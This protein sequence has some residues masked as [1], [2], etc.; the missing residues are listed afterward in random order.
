MEQIMI[1]IKD[2]ESMIKLGELLVDYAYPN[3]VIAL[4]GDLGAGKTTLTKGIGKALGVKRVINSPTFT[5][6][7]VYETTNEK[8]KKLYHLDVYR[9]TNSEDDF[10]LEEYFY[11]DGLAVIEW[12]HIIQ[13]MLPKNAWEIEII[14]L[15]D[16]TRQVTIK[17]SSELINKLGDGQY[18]I[19]HR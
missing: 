6:M 9:I 19:I 5:I 12:A 8:I 1:K 15:G 14:D 4:V 10:E 16:D 11:L 7:K 2:E 13:D 3:L 18:E 17:A